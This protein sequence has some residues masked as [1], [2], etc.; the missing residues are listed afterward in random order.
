M[1]VS[2]K[3]LVEFLVDT[4]LASRKALLVAEE[5][6]QKLGV[7]LERTAV[8]SGLISEND[9]RRA[10]AH[11]LGVPF[12]DL[13][14]EKL[15]LSVL[16]LVPEPIS[17]QHN[18]VA[19]RRVGNTLEVAFLDLATLPEVKFIEALHSL[20]IAPR[21]TDAES[22]KRALTAYREEL[23]SEFG[24]VIERESRGL[25][26]WTG[27]PSELNDSD[28]RAYA[29]EGRTAR[30]LEAVLGHALMSRA[31]N[32]HI[33]PTQE[34]VRVRY[35]LGGSMLDA[36]ILPKRLASRI[37][38]RARYLAGL[39]LRNQLPQDGTINL[40]AGAGRAALRL[41][42]APSVHGEKLMLRVLSAGS[43]GFA[44]ESLGLSG[45]ALE[46]LEKVLH[47]K[48]GLIIAA[49][50]EKSG[51]S[52]F[53]YTAL[54]ILDRPEINIQTVEERIEY[55]VARA[56]QTQVDAAKGLTFPRAL[57]AAAAQDTRSLVM[58]SQSRLPQQQRSPENLFLQEL[59]PRV[60][61]MASCGSSS[62][63]PISVS[64]PRLS[65]SR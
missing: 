40:D 37:A 42:T 48:E 25:A 46:A 62:W 55:R 63:G 4:G 52:T 3:E 57:R 32:I 30:V 28:L 10:T 1:H 13:S 17:R 65:R 51:K 23:R 34:D 35:R 38:L 24:S 54:D 22:L 14:E 12:V 47:K 56:T 9:L 36:A 58:A 19:Y 21:L 5:E 33:E 26:E 31:T 18:A 7:G 60:L 15:D 8:M 59:V 6:A 2:E 41:H 49:G 20:S 44:L 29:E 43:A 16:G 39:D 50:P 11:L 64:W 61:L 53:L 45:R 27:E